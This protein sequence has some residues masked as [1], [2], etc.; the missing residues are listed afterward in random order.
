MSIELR[1]LRNFLTLVELGSF[2]RAAAALQLSQPAL[3]RSIQALER[4]LGADVVLRAPTGIVPTDFGRVLMQR[5]RALLQLADEFDR[6]VLHSN[7]LQSGHVGVGAG[8]YP[9]ETIFV[10]ALTRFVAAHPLIK[11]RLQ[12]RA[13]DE[14]LLRL[15]G[16]EL[17]F[18]VAEI[19]T[20]TREA[21]LEIEPLAEHPVHFVARSGHPLAAKAQVTARDAVAYPIVTMSRVPP[22]ILEPMLAAQRRSP[23][24]AAAARPIPAIENA[25]LAAVKQMVAGSDVISAVPVACIGDELHSGKM[26]L[27]GTEP[28]LRLNYGVVTLKGR[29]LGPAATTLRQYVV[30]AETQLATAESKLLAR[31]A[32][33]GASRLPE[34]RAGSPKKDRA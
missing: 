9:A 5:A 17:D 28:W 6:D 29:V 23:S 21:D 10:S 3:T 13:W 32:R 7:T 33:R 27:L 11:V 16:R 31:F 15:R 14:L 12:V 22:R 30:E 25:T 18:F 2:G 1:P 24:P 20:L 4:Q 26:R 34:K 8:P 19:S